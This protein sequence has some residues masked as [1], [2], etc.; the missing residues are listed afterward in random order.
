M[1][2]P[3]SPLTLVLG[4]EELLASR[5]VTEVL[6]AARSLDPDVEVRERAGAELLPGE[7]AELLSPSLFGGPK[8]LVVRGGQDVRKDAAAA[9]LASVPDLDAQASLVVTHLGGNKGR[10]LAE[11]LRKAG[12]RVM[13]AAKITRPRERVEF[14]RN[15][16]RRLGDRPT[17]EVAEALLAAVGTDLRELVAACSQLV[18]DTGGGVDAATVARYYRGRAEGSGFAVADAVMVGDVG[19]ALEALRWAL[20]TGVDPVPIAD[21]LADGVRSVARVAAAGRGSAHQLASGLGLPPWK[22]ERAQRQARGWT[23]TGLVDAMRAAEWCNG[24]VKGGA[25]DRGYALE[26][27]VFAVAAARASGGE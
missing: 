1:A 17:E 8:V 26:K 4:D 6:D 22:I 14:V 10:A 18:A 12:A 7:L 15:E 20:Q 24:A 11:G 23:A 25:E 9:L 16:F 2:V 5:A 13:P 3:A 19:G 27:T 21:A